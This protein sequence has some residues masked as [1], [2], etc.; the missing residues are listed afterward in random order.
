MSFF[1]FFIVYL[2]VALF[3][4]QFYT[5][6]KLEDKS[7]LA[8]AVT[9]SVQAQLWVWGWVWWRWGRDTRAPQRAVTLGYSLGSWQHQ[10]R[11]SI[12]KSQDLLWPWW[13]YPCTELAVQQKSR[14]L[15]LTNLFLQHA[16]KHLP[17][18]GEL[19]NGSGS[20]S[21]VMVEQWTRQMNQKRQV[22]DKCKKAFY[23]GWSQSYPI[24]PYPHPY[25]LSHDYTTLA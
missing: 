9:C 16:K 2:F 7:N 10:S 18:H 6:C 15:K 25:F 19:G 3:T 21:L 20:G 8:V 23:L 12:S 24:P 4:T 13:Q 11:L 1:S 17:F 14:S 22:S 5:V